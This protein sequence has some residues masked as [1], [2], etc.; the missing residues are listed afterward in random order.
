MATATRIK[1][2]MNGNGKASSVSHGEEPQATI[3]IP[4]LHVHQLKIK[5]VGITPL[6]MCKFDEKVRHELEAKTEGRAAN[7][8]APKDPEREWNAAR[9]ISTE[10]WDGIHAGGIRGAIIDAARSVEG[11]TMTALKQ[12]VFVVADG[13][14]EDG[15]PLIRIYG[16][17]VKFSAMCRTT[18]G[19]AYPRHRPMY[20]PW[21]AVVRLEINSHLLSVEAAVNLISLAGWSCGLGEWRPTS[22]KSKTG[23]QGRFKVEGVEGT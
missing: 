23:D 13:R 21:S 15:A 3:S 16:E 9:W 2:G 20:N 4:K 12:A 8:K 22:P 19:V 6:V 11:L 5:I 7:R 1:P 10:G 18:T 17:P 14:S